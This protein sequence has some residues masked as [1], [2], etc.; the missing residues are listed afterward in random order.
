M[1][2]KNWIQIIVGVI[3][4]AVFLKLINLADSLHIVSQAI[5]PIFVIAMLTSVVTQVLR[6][7]RF[8]HISRSINVDTGIKKSI[9]VQFMTSLAGIATPAKI[10][11]GGKILFF[12]NKNKLTFSFILEKIADFSLQFLIGF[13]AIFTFQIYVDLFYFVLVLFIIGIIALFKIDKILNFVLR[14]NE[15]EKGWFFNILKGINKKS[16]LIFSVLTFL[17]WFNINLSVWVYALSLGLVLDMFLLFQ[18]FTVSNLMGTISGTPGGIGSTQIVFTFMMVTFMGVSSS[19][20]GAVAIISVIGIYI[21]YTILTLIGFL[22][23]RRFFKKQ[24]SA[25]PGNNK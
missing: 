14:K 5:W 25:L 12:K 3:I 2:K 16:F 6:G 7:L 9:L 13:L 4:L 10:G 24:D 22:L 20:A 11:E 15:F 18:I 19:L 8:Y 17:L 21:I 1:N 23:Y